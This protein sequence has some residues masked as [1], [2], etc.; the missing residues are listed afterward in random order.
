LVLGSFTAVAGFFVYPEMFG[1]VI[2]EAIVTGIAVGLL[3]YLIGQAIAYRKRNRAA[4]VAP[5]LD[6]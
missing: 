6:S 4:E 2:T 3:S 5:Y 1:G